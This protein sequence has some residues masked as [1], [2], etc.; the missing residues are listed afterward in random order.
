MS[1]VSTLQAGRV[2]ISDYEDAQGRRIS[3]N[4]GP[5][6]VCCGKPH[7]ECTCVPE[8]ILPGDRV[9]N[10][11]MRQATA[12]EMIAFELTKI[13]KHLEGEKTPNVTREI[14]PAMVI[15]PGA[16]PTA[17]GDAKKAALLKEMGK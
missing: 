2:E 13:R 15:G 8:P 1:I 4:K 6:A 10:P 11:A 16:P 5:I 9:E 3:T 12:M 14:T 7:R 17:A